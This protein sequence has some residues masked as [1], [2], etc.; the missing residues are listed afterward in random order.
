MKKQVKDLLIKHLFLETVGS[1]MFELDEEDG[2]FI[3]YFNNPRKEYEKII[4]LIKE[5]FESAVQFSIEEILVGLSRNIRAICY[6]NGTEITDV[7]SDEELLDIAEMAYNELL[8][9]PE[10]GL[11]LTQEL[12][13][14]GR[15]LNDEDAF[16]FLQMLK[17]TSENDYC[18]W[19]KY[20]K[21]KF[22]IKSQI[23]KF[24]KTKI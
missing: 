23:D 9:N 15:I 14:S 1:L 21:P 2:V 3:D 4:P 18:E 12:D 7:F 17:V 19:Y 6:L 16:K 5:E 13:D 22:L 11:Y 24:L 10:Y 8:H 20:I